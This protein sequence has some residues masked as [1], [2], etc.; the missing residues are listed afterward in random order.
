[1]RLFLKDLITFKTPTLDVYYPN[2][3]VQCNVRSWFSQQIISN[4]SIIIR[5]VFNG[6]DDIEV[7]KCP[8]VSDAWSNSEC[9]ANLVTYDCKE[10]VK[11]LCSIES[12]EIDVQRTTNVKI[13]GLY[14]VMYFNG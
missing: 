14:A 10:H 8:L 5:Q 13:T 1:M 6:N 11:L 2:D 9:K 12:K 3:T 4:A 7:A